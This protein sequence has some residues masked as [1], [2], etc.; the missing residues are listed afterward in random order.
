MYSRTLMN[1]LM[2]DTLGPWSL[3]VEV[4]SGVL[5]YRPSGLGVPEQWVLAYE[6]VSAGDRCRM[7]ALWK[8]RPLV[9]LET[10]RCRFG[11]IS[12]RKRAA[13]GSFSIPPTDHAV[14]T[15]NGRGGAAPHRDASLPWSQP[16]AMAAENSMGV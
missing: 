12:T 7:Q 3:H 5:A 16:R 11:P 14:P 1:R 8:R 4:I 2:G 6:S 13:S 9:K 15:A 10:M